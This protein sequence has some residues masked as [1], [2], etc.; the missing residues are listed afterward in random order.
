M[1]D[2]SGVEDPI[3]AIFDLADR[4][5]EM[6]PTVRRMYR[7]TATILVIWIIVT[8]FVTFA[9]LGSALWLAVLSFLGLVAGVIAL[10]LLRRTDRFFGSFVLRH[11]SIRLVRDADPIVKVPDGRTPVERL[12]RYLIQSNPRVGATVGEDPASMRY[13]VVLPA[14]G[15]SRPFDL[16]VVRPAGA[17]WRAFG[18]GETGFAILARVTGESV[19]IDD[20][21]RMEADALAVA[22]PLGAAVVRLILL[23][24]KPGPLPE[25][26]Y[27]Y[28]VGHPVVFRRAFGSF[29]AN[30]EVITENPDGTY[31][32]VPHVL[33]VP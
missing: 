17:A 22:P 31:D 6:A 14:A 13:R 28:A 27:E 21:R 30:L 9:T 16:V 1:V 10:T 23:R 3:S 4:A 29:R 7:Y 18:R 2:P 26:A 20:L 8:A 12:G 11:R 19:T 33:G 32:F 5:A 24:P 15:E 25:E